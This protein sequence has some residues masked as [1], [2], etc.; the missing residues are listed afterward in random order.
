MPSRELRSLPPPPLQLSPAVHRQ[1]H[2]L[3]PPL[4]GGIAAAASLLIL[5]TF[6]FRKISLKRTVPSSD[7]ESKPPHRFSYNS[8]RRATSNFSPL[9]RLGQGGFGPVY[10][11]TV[12]SPSSNSNVSVAVKVMDSG[13]LQGERE[14]QNE[15]FFAGK[16]DSKYIV[17]TIGFSSD[18]RGRRMLLVYELLVNRSLQDCLLHRKCSELKDWK[19]RLSIAID[20]AKG[21]EYL[22]HYCDPPTIHGDIKPSNILLDD[23]FNAKIGDFGLA[24]LKVEDHVEIEVRKE[25]PLGG[26]GTEDNGSVAE[27]TESVIT[28]NGVDEFHR[29]VEQSPESFVKLEASPETVVTG[30][31]LSPEAPVVSPRTV[32]AMASP[33]EGLEKTSLSEGNFDRSSID[34]GI[35]IGHK[36]SGVKKKRSITG[37]D[38]WWKQDTG[39]TD[40]GVVKDYVME[41]IGNEIKKERPKT[42]WIGASSS[43][44]P[45]GKTEKKKHRKRLD[46]WVSLDD[47]KNVKKEKRR[48][49]REWWKEEYCEELARKKKKKK[50]QQG[51]IGSVSDDCH[52]ES[53][54]PRDDELYSAKK[55]KRSRSRSSKSSMDW[56]LDGFS[57]ELRRARKNS[58]DSAS[59]EIP[60]SGG[61]SSTPSMRGTVCYVAPEYGSCGDLSEKCDVY[62]YGVLLLVLI[63]GRRPLQVTGSPMS[64]FQRANLLSWARHLA[65]A[66]KL[67][68]LV[69]QSVESLDKEQALLC[70]TVALLCLQKSP[71]CRPSMKEVVGM[72][73]G[74]LEAPQL[75]VELSPSPP[76]RFPFKSHKRVR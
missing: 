56:W 66:G 2:N 71:A 24:R 10:R 8:L 20:I 69:D 52:S 58:Y 3:L 42:E 75:P 61:I 23:N 53:W 14:F 68:D 76:S 59:G 9:L 37:K 48:P 38:W 74:D 5:F 35:E 73:S 12:K 27:D 17:S 32:A 62:S 28:V 39:G 63:A 44:G 64:E 31:E 60:K 55:K 46:W 72:L 49:A 22:H 7:S 50:K 47:E 1:S 16:I 70:I 43:S 33:S 29:G 21:L 6:C 25:S 65:R 41:W 19:K 30:V 54:W 34:S 67:L 13:S 26:L 15:L 18:K 51:G 57:S 36:K 11:G 45:V 40:S 4:A